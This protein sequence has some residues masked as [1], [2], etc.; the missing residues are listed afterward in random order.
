MRLLAVRLVRVGEGRGRPGSCSVSL[1]SLTTRRYSRRPSRE[2]DRRP[3]ASAT[4]LVGERTAR[5]RRTCLA[6]RRREGRRLFVST[7]AGAA[8][9]RPRALDKPTDDRNRGSDRRRR[10]HPVAPAIHAAALLLLTA[11]PARACDLRPRVVTEHTV[12]PPGSPPRTLLP[13]CLP[14]GSPTPPKMAAVQTIVLPHLSHAPVH[15]ALFK[16]VKNA[17]YLRRQLLE[18]NQAFEYAFL[19]ATAVCRHLPPP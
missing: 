14:P 9:S 13:V 8:P 12:P 2:R 1:C 3:A 10:A 19:D 6:G 5:E 15:V 7:G 17:A 4:V 18:G 16:D 11:A